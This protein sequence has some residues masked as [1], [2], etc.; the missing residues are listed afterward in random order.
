MYP[1]DAAAAAAADDDDDG[2]EKSQITP[3]WLTLKALKIL[4]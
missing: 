4:S 1:H 2:Y 3:L